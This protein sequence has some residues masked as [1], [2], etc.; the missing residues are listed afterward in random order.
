MKIS[1][2]FKI[3]TFIFI[4]FLFVNNLFANTEFPNNLVIHDKPK[5]TSNITFKD[6]NLQDVDLS[7]NKGKIMILNFWATWC[8]PCKRLDPVLDSFKLLNP[9][10]DVVIIN[11]DNNK[12]VANLYEV[13]SVPTVLVFKNKNLI[14][15][16][17]GYLNHEYL[18]EKAYK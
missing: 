1:K 6:I 9:S 12:D 16:E 17:T 13:N 18:M 8:L 10:W 15:K 14:F 11:M 2:S 3:I 5:K 4:G 7:K